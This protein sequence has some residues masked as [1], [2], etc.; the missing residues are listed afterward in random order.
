DFKT[1]KYTITPNNLGKITISQGASG[2][3]V[4]ISQ[5]AVTGG[6]GE[7]IENKYIAGYPKNVGNV[8]SYIVTGLDTTE[9]YY[10]TVTPSNSAESEEIMV[11]FSN[12]STDN[13]PTYQTNNDIIYYIKDN[14][15]VVTNLYPSKSL[16]VYN[17]LGQLVLTIDKVSQTETLNL[18]QGIYLIQHNNQTIKIKN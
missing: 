2:E 15:V 4:V 5:L 16:N 6:S 12:L 1:Y 18:P 8:T 10:Y 17:T 14:I 3:R 11:D 7:V 13:T 9:I